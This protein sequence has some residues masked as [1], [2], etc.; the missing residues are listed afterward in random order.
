M[1]RSRSGIRHDDGPIP[2][3]YA[4]RVLDERERVTRHL[5]WFAIGFA[6]VA[7]AGPYL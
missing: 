2:Q 3:D 7:F 1:T 4:V 5:A 6:L